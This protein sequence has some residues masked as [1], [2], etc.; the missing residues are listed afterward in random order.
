MTRTSKATLAPPRGSAPDRR[1]PRHPFFRPSLERLELRRLLS[2]AASPTLLNNYADWPMMFEANQGQTASQVRFLSH[3]NGYA[4]LPDRHRGGPQPDQPVRCERLGRQRVRCADDE[5]ARQ[6][7]GAGVTGL[8]EVAAKSNYLIGNDPSQWHTDVPNYASVGYQGVYPGIDLTYYGSGQQ[9]E[10]DFTV[11]PGADPAAIRLNF[12]GD[13]GMEIDCAG[14][15]RAAHRRRRRGGARPGPVPGGWADRQTVSGGYV[16]GADGSVGFTVG[17][18]DPSRPLVIDPVLIYSTFLG[19][20][21]TTPGGEGGLL[22][23]AAAANA[24]AADNAGDVYLTGTIDGVTGFPTSQG[25]LQVPFNGY[26]DDAYVTKLN[27]DGQIVFS[28]YLGGQGDESGVQTLPNGVQFNGQYVNNQGTGIAVH[29][30]GKGNVSVYVTGTTYWQMPG[31]L[32]NGTWI[33]LAP[34]KVVNAFQPNHPNTPEGTNAFVAE[35]NPNG[36]GLVYSSYLGQ[37]SDQA[38]GIAVDAAGNAYVVGTT[39]GTGLFAARP[40]VGP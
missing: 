38:N 27:A 3:G 30:D 15:P 23:G 12:Q 5:L 28:T 22:V 6:Q 8:D 7:P 19:N 35:L 40:Y 16:L 2:G 11:A 14:R 10:Y 25:A 1:R 9:L 17:A 24:V 33:G 20:S 37:T 32:Y 29:D 36:T 21:Y 13:T 31:V 26:G 18:Y 34:D 39:A 4:A